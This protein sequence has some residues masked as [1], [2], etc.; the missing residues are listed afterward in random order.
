VRRGARPTVAARWVA[1]ERA[2]HARTRPFTPE[3]D[4]EGERL[5]YRGVAGPFAAAP[6]GRSPAAAARLRVID[7]EV[8]QAI[9]RGIGQIVLLGAGYDGRALRFG[10]AAVRWFEVDRAAT[11]A[12]KRRRLGALGRDPA[13]I[14][15]V[16]ANLSA[17]DPAAALA[18]AGHDGDRPSLFV[19]DGLVTRLTL[20]ATAT[21]FDALRARAAPGSVLVVD[22]RVAPEAGGPVRALRV[23]T[24]LCLRM[25][26]E[27][28]RIE[29]RP[30]DPE[31]LMVVTG[32]H[33]TQAESAAERGLDRGAHTLVLACE[34]AP[35]RRA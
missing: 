35:P 5:L 30:G 24:D 33:V 9:G 3:G 11:Q 7:A 13:T 31:K 28:K 6:V 8:A 21:L 27:P 32:W 25:I 34:P 23:A 22:C 17:D 19:G 4:L 12:D 29:L 2:R 1:A 14:A 26:G 18:A 15:Y 20:E 10:G 16:S